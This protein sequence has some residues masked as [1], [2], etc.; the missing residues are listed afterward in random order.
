MISLL[1]VCS[2]ENIIDM[3]CNFFSDKPNIEYIS[4]ENA[5]N[6]DENLSEYNIDCVIIGNGDSINPIK[7][8]DDLDLNIPC[9][10]F[11]D[12]GSEELAFRCS[13]IGVKQYINIDIYDDPLKIL[14][15]RVLESVS[16]RSDKLHK[17]NSDYYFNQI[18]KLQDTI[19]K[20]FTIKDMDIALDLVRDC[21]IESFGYQMVGIWIKE[22][23]DD[24]LKPKSISDMA[25]DIIGDEQPDY[26]KGNSIYWVAYENN[27]IKI[28]DDV[29]ENDN[30]N[31]DSTLIRSEAIVPM[32][33]LGVINIASL[34]RDAFTRKESELMKL[35]AESVKIA[36]D[37]IEKIKDLEESQKE[38][39]KE[40]KR[41]SNFV[42][43]V[44]HDV[45]NPLQIA[46]G[47]LDIVQ[48]E[49]DNDRLDT[50]EDS[51]NRIETI[52]SDIKVLT[53]QRRDE[54]DLENVNIEDLVN[55]CWSNV[56]TEDTTLINDVEL[57]VQAD[58]S[59]L[60]N[61]FENLFKNAVSHGGPDVDIIVDNLKSSKGFYVEDTGGGIDEKIIDSLFES[62]VTTGDEGSGFGLKI[63][64]EVVNIHDWR[65]DVE[66]TFRGARFNIY[67][68]E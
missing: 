66:N 3:T 43:F 33:D 60:A 59:K 22:D 4:V 21:F 41:M 40:K 46:K 58:D 30:L 8:C 24:V 15:V 42:S 65:I 1:H 57:Q 34:E 47:N 37:R 12:K 20:L 13:E 7:I 45:R 11:T 51:L 62:G 31:N 53:D 55:D 9:I 49:V 39:I 14:E 52:I 17:S 54:L 18:T 6:I 56:K 25:N 10:V 19:S 44:T 67:T 5:E 26:K 23:E 16:D 2:D 68:D 64:S 48:S 29:T 61:L 28:I 35:W 38:L 63:V 32:D 50:V 27:E 36:L